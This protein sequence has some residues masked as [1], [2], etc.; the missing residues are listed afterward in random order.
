MDTLDRR[1][2]FTLGSLWISARQLYRVR[3]SVV[4]QVCDYK[5]PE[6]SSWCLPWRIGDGGSLSWTL[7]GFW[8]D[9]MAN[10]NKTCKPTRPLD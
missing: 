9:E 4:H 3:A 2:H 8:N 5:Y 10:V 7:M 1:L 6:Q